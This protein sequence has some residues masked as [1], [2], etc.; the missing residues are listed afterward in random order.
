MRDILFPLTVNVT[1]E[2]IRADCAVKKRTL[3][4]ADATLF[5]LGMG[6]PKTTHPEGSSHRGG[7]KEITRSTVLDSTPIR[8]LLVERGGRHGRQE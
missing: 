5:F 6:S 1:G 2:G 4:R 8:S 3:A 7:R